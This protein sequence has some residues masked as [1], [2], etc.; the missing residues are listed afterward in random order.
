MSK[1]RSKVKR[2]NKKSIGMEQGKTGRIVI[3][4]R[5]TKGFALR[6][7]KWKERDPIKYETFKQGKGESFNAPALAYMINKAEELYGID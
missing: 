1:Q 4:I 6:M 2:A 7:K 3:P 5:P